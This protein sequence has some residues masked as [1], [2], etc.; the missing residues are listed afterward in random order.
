MKEY[1]IW[2]SGWAA[3]GGYAHARLLGKAMGESFSEACK[4]FDME[5]GMNFTYLPEGNPY[6]E[7][8]RASITCWGCSLHDN[9]ADARK[10]FG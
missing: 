9:E 7:N 10:S 2:Q 5:H 8:G 3:T 4:K 1:Q 6:T